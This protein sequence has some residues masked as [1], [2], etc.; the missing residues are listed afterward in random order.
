MG[1]AKAN[2]RAKAKADN[3]VSRA[4]KVK[5]SLVEAVDARGIGAAANGRTTAN[6]RAPRSQMATRRHQPIRRLL[7]KHRLHLRNQA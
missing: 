1:R 5:G 4:S 6:S 3:R 7:S 2:P